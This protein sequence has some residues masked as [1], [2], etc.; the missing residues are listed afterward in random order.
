M[1]VVLV[2]LD[3]VV[4]VLVGLVVLGDVG[5]TELGVVG[6]SALRGGS[7]SGDSP[8]ELISVTFGLSLRPISKPWRASR[9]A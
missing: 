5:G 1:V 3:V 7:S 2:V 8:I 4:L 6:K 9:L